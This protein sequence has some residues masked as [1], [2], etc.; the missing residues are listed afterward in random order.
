[1]DGIRT[2]VEGSAELLAALKD[3]DLNG[4]EDAM[5][6]TNCPEGCYVEPDGHCCHGFKSLGLLMGLI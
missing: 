3:G 4:A 2:D 1:M 5:G 6:Q